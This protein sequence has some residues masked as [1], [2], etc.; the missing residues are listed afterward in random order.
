MQDSSYKIHLHSCAELLILN[1]RLSSM[2]IQGLSY[3]I[4]DRF[5]KIQGH[6]Q[7]I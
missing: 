2:K 4:E 7:E 5:Y 6:S 1:L 3:T